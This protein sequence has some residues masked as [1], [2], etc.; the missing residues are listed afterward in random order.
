MRRRSAYTY[1]QA[2]V[3][4]FTLLFMGS[5]KPDTPITFLSSEFVSISNYIEEHQDEYGQFWKLMQATDLSYTLNAKPRSRDFTL[6]LP[7]DDAFARFYE[8]STRYKKLEDIIGDPDFA[9]NL[10]RYHVVTNSLVT[11]DFP[12]GSLP[13]ST[14]SGD[15]L[16]IG[17]TVVED[18]TYYYVNNSS[19]IIA[20]NMEMS[21]GYIHVIDELLEPVT[22]SS[23]EW[24]TENS[25]YSIFT[26]A[27]D[28]TGL[29]DT[30][31]IYRTNTLGNTIRNYYT[32]FAEPDSIFSRSGINSLDDLVTTYS[33]PGM[34][35]DDPGNDLYQFMAY[36]LLEDN[37]FLDD[38]SD[39]S[40]NYNTYANFPVNINCGLE[41]KINPSKDSIDSEISGSDTLIYK[42]VRLQI[43]E[44]NILT[45]NGAIH[46]LKN[47][48]NVYS[49]SPTS[50]T[51]Q[52]FNETAIDE[53][54]TDVGEHYF[55]PQDMEVL[56]WTGAEQ[57]L[58]VKMSES[59][60]ATSSDY[61]KISG[62]FSLEYITPR[63][64]PGKY[65]L[66]MKAERSLNE[67]AT[68]QVYLDGNRMGSSF[69]LTSG[70]SPFSTFVLGTVEFLF[71]EPHTLRIT[72]LLP[73]TLIW[74]S[75]LFEPII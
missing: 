42:Y 3:L 28:L 14:A 32:V 33:T 72:T 63:I 25:A 65:T 35:P 51:F 67:N 43:N 71:Y 66:K 20:P 38:F 12:F 17:F 44:C 47:V 50:L 10:I 69:D 26:Q 39:G 18:T 59:N 62:N 27:L 52:F 29:A 21:N 60:G 9:A 46:V 15:Y 49:P 54:R 48:M 7:E 34:E 37:M 45:K 1:I 23:Y 53:I 22:F 24:L 31:G 57:L 64:L 36:H 13:D 41:I 55:Y 11:N 56:S 2:G 75:L 70:G 40:I 58:Y 61:I 8:K 68:I 30:M 19:R 4:A 16:T 6:F 73:G 5:C 74:D